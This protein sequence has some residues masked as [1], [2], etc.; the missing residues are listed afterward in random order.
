MEGVENGKLCINCRYCGNLS[1]ARNPDPMWSI[2]LVSKVV[3]LVTGTIITQTSCSEARM[4]GAPCGPEG[5][6]YE[7]K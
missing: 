7:P 5:R 2:C 1:T 3:D 4:D 6:L